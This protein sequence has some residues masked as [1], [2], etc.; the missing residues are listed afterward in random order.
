MHIRRTRTPV[1]VALE[2]RR[3]PLFPRVHTEA[4]PV[5]HRENTKDVVFQAITGNHDVYPKIRSMKGTLIEVLRVLFSCLRPFLQAAR[6]NINTEYRF[7]TESICRKYV[8]RTERLL[9]IQ[10]RISDQTIWFLKMFSR[11]SIKAVCA[12]PRL[13]LSI[14][15]PFKMSHFCVF[16]ALF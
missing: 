5:F 15:H 10:K 3:E 13:L 4:G 16:V 2:G 12:F 14:K 6:H 9:T 8:D 1:K 7:W 11:A